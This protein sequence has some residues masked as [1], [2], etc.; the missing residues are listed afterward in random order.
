MRLENYGKGV[1]AYLSTPSGVLIAIGLSVLWITFLVLQEDI[2]KWTKEHWDWP[3]PKPKPTIDRLDAIELALK[4]NATKQDVN[5]VID[6]CTQTSELHNKL[7]DLNS[8]A[9]GKLEDDRTKAIGE[10]SDLGI[11]LTKI[12]NFVATELAPLPKLV[13][14]TSERVEAATSLL[15]DHG[16]RL[17][18]HRPWISDLQR[19]LALLTKR[20]GEVIGQ[21][22]GFS[23][24]MLGVA[25]LISE[26]EMLLD[27]LHQIRESFP[28]HQAAKT[29]F[30][31]AW[32]RRDGPVSSPDLIIEWSLF[33]NWHIR[34]CESF[35]VESRFAQSIAIDQGLRLLA[36]TWN[37]DAS[38][39][40][41][42]GRLGSHRAKLIELR[43]NH[44]A[45]FST[46]AVK[47]TI[48]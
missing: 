28:E 15:L 46:E 23:I 25:R 11:R 2:L 3:A 37:N 40:D 20:R 4:D 14:A 35:A 44:A 42:F 41:S 39:N 12:E 47:L 43:D 45:N 5:V 13:E 29:P 31:Q 48:S 8:K 33:V 32:W 7:H 1:W 6:L 38:F 10:R 17:E 27:Y 9:I 18:E 34:H 21:I 36:S 22:P 30:S 24:F 26:A 19:T 16:G